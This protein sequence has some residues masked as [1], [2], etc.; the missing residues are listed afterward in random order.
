MGNLAREGLRTLVVACKPLTAAQYEHFRSAM[1]AAKL[2]KTNRAGAVRAVWDM[3]QEEMKLLAVTAV[4]DRLQVVMPPRV[5]LDLRRTAP[6]QS[7]LLLCGLLSSPLLSLRLASSIF[8]SSS[9]T[10]C[11]N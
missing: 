5:P 7:L 4:E 10:N 3:L 1:G 2:A 8:F 11:T 9:S 6:P